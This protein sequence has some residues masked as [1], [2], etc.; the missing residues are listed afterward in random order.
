MKYIFFDID[1]TLVSHIGTSHIPPQTL[2]AIS[3]LKE[4]GHVPAIATGRGAFLSRSVAREF[5]I[6]YLV[7][8]GGSQVI[9]KGNEIFSSWFP[10]DKLGSFIKT[11][12]DFPDRTAAIDDRYLYASNAFSDFFGYFNAQAGYDCIRPLSELRHAIICYIMLPSRV[13]GP[14]HGMFFSCPE[15]V[16][17]ELMR[18]FTEARCAGSSKWDGIERLIDHEGADIDDVIVFGDG[19]N[20]VEMIERASIGVAVGR[21]SGSAK[22]AADYVC[23]DIDAGGILSACEY[24]GLV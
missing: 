21:S 6:E 17:L 11:A 1:N 12:S 15:G 2:K 19:P 22:G 3:L 24:L 7:C 10:D 23:D 14:E 5:G 9:A 18:D 13:L 20:D 4:A 16:R 8:S